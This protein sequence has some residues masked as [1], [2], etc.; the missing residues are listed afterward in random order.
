M[1]RLTYSDE[2]LERVDELLDAERSVYTT[3]PD[4]PPAEREAVVAR[5]IEE[6]DYDEIAAASGGTPGAIRQRVSRGLAKLARLGGRANEPDARGARR[7][8]RA[9]QRAH[10]GGRSADPSPPGAAPHRGY[11]GSDSAPARRNRRHRRPRQE[12]HRRAGGGQAARDRGPSGPPTGSRVRFQ[13]A[14]GAG[15]RPQH[16]R[17]GV[18]GE[19][20][21]GMHLVCRLR[22]A[23]AACEEASAAAR[24]WRTS[25]GGSSEGAPLGSA[26]R[27]ASI[28]AP[29]S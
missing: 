13:A 27:M 23:G 20:R 7:P 17:R 15:G 5:V 19:E 22:G 28:S 6:R 3:A 24:R 14:Q 8:R 9:P 10:H 2:A 16:E 4:L 12:H 18:P 11:R 26:P 29:T 25:T 21:L 1:V